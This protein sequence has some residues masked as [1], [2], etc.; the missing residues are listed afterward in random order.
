MYAEHITAR[1]YMWNL[2]HRVHSQIT[3]RMHWHLYIHIYTYLLNTQRIYILAE[4]ITE[5][6][7]IT[8]TTVWTARSLY[9]CIDTYI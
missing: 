7:S 2:S 3:L 6:F 8:Y 1:F 9:V 4:H 5:R